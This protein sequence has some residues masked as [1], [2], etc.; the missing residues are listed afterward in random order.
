[1]STVRKQQIKVHTS[2]KHGQ[3]SVS[4]VQGVP[5]ARGLQVTAVLR[6]CCINATPCSLALSLASSFPYALEDLSRSLS[7]FARSF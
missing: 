4:Q 5:S 7:L 6:L 3:S 1:M 2:R